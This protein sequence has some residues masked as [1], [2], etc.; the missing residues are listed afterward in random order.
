MNK[1]TK[2]R[3][4]EQDKK[5]VT[6]IFL[7][8]FFSGSSLNT[9]EHKYSSSLEIISLLFKLLYVIVSWGSCALLDSES[10]SSWLTRS[11]LLSHEEI[12][13]LYDLESF[14]D[15]D[16]CHLCL[17]E[18]T[19]ISQNSSC[20]AEISVMHEKCVS[21]GRRTACLMSWLDSQEEKRGKDTWYALLPTVLSKVALHAWDKVG[22]EQAYHMLYTLL[23][24]FSTWNTIHETRDML[25]LLLLSLRFLCLPFLSSVDGT[26]SDIC[27][28]FGTLRKQ[29]VTNSLKLLVHDQV[30]KV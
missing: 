21:L 17:E 22:D 9:K 14:L 13:I 10:S 20:N 6:L 12:I 19:G 3:T 29:K 30:S 27:P 15:N 4:K 18:V 28:H 23:E 16:I 7:S 1:T 24:H 26:R 11:H 5:N 2:S 8:S 25:Y